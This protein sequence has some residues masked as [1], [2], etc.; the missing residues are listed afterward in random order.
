MKIVGL[1]GMP[2]T[3]K[4]TLMRSLI[5]RLKGEG[6]IWH[7]EKSGTLE[8]LRMGDFYVLGKYDGQPFDGTDR[9]SMTDRKSVV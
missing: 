1:C 9:L 3:G 5:E 6:Q 8:Y 2:A 7:E 4:S